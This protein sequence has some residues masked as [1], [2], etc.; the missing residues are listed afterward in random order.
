[1]SYSINEQETTINVFPKAVSDKAEI[2]TCIPTMMDR[3]RKLAKEYPTDVCIREED[4]ALFCTVP[5]G[6]VKV[7]PKR[8][9]TL[10][11]EQKAANAARL[12]AYREVKQ[13]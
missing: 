11:E 3:M 12:A 1:M 13:T 2:F 5:I 8:K 7:A 10:T 4:G 9:C 6:W